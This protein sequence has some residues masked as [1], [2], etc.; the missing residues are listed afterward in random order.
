MVLV[1]HLIGSVSGEQIKKHMPGASSAGGK[2]RI[3]RRQ[4]LVLVGKWSYDYCL[5]LFKVKRVIQGPSSVN[6]QEDE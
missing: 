2:C 6:A 4:V 3:W 5:G 1:V